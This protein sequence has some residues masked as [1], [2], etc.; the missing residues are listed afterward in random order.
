MVNQNGNAL[1]LILIAVA[2][3]AALSYAVTQSS[4]QTGTQ[5]KETLRLQAGELLQ[6]GAQLQHAA[7]RMKLINGCKEGQLSFNADWDG[8]GQVRNDLS[9]DQANTTSPSD[10][11]CRFFANNGGNVPFI[12]AHRFL[13]DD[14]GNVSYRLS[15]TA[16]VL[17]IGSDDRSELL[18]LF[19]L[20]ENEKNRKL[21][22]AYNQILGLPADL[23]D[24]H[25][26]HTI[27][28]FSWGGSFNDGATVGGRQIGDG[29]TELNGQPAGCF[30]VLHYGGGG[31]E[32]Y[33]V[34]LE[35]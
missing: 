35:R 17:G 1:F 21:C 28:Y 31:Y 24:G 16:S 6:Y 2:L 8:D 22:N 11:R 18:F 9:S 23:E 34:I 7:Q 12:K 29:A 5:N 14:I 32:F 27:G 25:D 19:R 4:R 13:E 33:Y 15:G 10:G 20:V 26:R 30:K 3:F